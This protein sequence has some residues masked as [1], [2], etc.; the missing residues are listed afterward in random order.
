MTGLRGHYSNCFLNQGRLS[1]A[2]GKQLPH[3]KIEKPTFIPIHCL[4]P[5]AKNSQAAKLDGQEDSW[6]WLV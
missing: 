5:L 4:P 3:D 2:L 1:V 6:V